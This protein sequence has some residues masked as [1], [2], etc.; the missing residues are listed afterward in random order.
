[1]EGRRLLDTLRNQH[2]ET[3]AFIYD[4]GQLIEDTQLALDAIRG[5]RTRLLFAM[6]AFTIP[7]GLEAIASVADGFHASSLFEAKLGRE[8]LGPGRVIH[9]TT[10]GIRPADAGELFELCDLVSF[11]SLTQWVGFREEATGRTGCGLRVN[12]R[13]S[14]VADERYDPCRRH[15]KLGVSIEEMRETLHS[16]PDLLDG[17]TGLMF[18]T[19]C[20]ALDTTP[21]LE[22]VRYLDHH[23]GNLLRRL[24]WIDLGGGYL[25]FGNQAPLAS[26][27][28]RPRRLF[29]CGRISGRRAADLDGL[30][31]ALDLLRSRYELTIYLEPGAS[32]SRRA[33]SFVASVIDTF[34]SAGR[35]VAV[36]DTTVNHMPE[37][38]EFD[39]HPDAVGD[40][41][42]GGYRCVL[43]G[44][45]CLAGDIF[46]EYAFANPPEVGSRVVFPNMGAYSMVKANFFN[47]V[48]LPSIYALGKDGTLRL[49]HM[50]SYND[51]LQHCGGL[52]HVRA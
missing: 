11:N 37:V 32:I 36:L 14:N 5:E 24:R 41:E 21:L 15:S 33:G 4:E 42:R 50:F 1:M 9:L 28:G 7:S 40:L 38:L 35:T 45:T 47:G 26:E 13:L 39:C 25:F 43:A 19:N 29:R 16:D 48:N 52:H 6:K 17:I 49:E 46:G 34:Q 20:D 30:H 23:L 18:H 27:D 12:P 44:A 2:I 8:I 3:P 31:Q 22:T 10:P 51:F